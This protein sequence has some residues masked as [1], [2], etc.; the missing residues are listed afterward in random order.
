MV[1]TPKPER[2]T[3]GR[4]IAQKARVIAACFPY[5]VTGPQGAPYVVTAKTINDISA[6]AVGEAV[7]GA[8]KNYGR[9]F[10]VVGKEHESVVLVSFEEDQP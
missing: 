7:M 3:Y 8:I 5:G 6:E 1:K 10:P 2:D 4:I 9:P